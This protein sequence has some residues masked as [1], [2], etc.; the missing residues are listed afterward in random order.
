MDLC[1]HSI[2]S[3]TGFFERHRSI[4]R[5]SVRVI[6]DTEKK[7]DL[8]LNLIYTMSGRK[9]RTGVESCESSRGTVQLT[10]RGQEIGRDVGTG[11]VPE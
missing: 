7:L 9:D 10:D 8:S 5:L 6:V 11:T 3:G 2:H 4:R 1:L